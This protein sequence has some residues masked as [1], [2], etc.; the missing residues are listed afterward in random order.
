MEW[1]PFMDDLN[2]LILK[3]KNPSSLKYRVYWGGFE[4]VYSSEA[5]SQGVNLAADFEE[6]PFS[7]AFKKVDQAVAAKQAYETRQIKQIFHGPEGRADAEMAAAL[8]E[9]TREPLVRAIRK[10]FKPVTHS[11]RLVGE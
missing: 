2:R 9:K 1:V 7:E 10:S 8:T 11:I 3:V 4:K 6:N 5:L